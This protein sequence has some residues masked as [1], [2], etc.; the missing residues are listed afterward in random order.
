MSYNA[1]AWPCKNNVKFQCQTHVAQNKWLRFVRTTMVQR[2]ARC[3][4]GQGEAKP[5]KI[6]NF[7][8]NFSGFWATSTEDY[9]LDNMFLRK[10]IELKWTISS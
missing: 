1:H 3:T 6:Q 9:T 7:D 4:V 5:L 10:K 8:W 2:T